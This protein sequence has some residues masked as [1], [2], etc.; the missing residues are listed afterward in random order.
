MDFLQES[1]GLGPLGLVLVF[2]FEEQSNCW[3]R[4]IAAIA[5]ETECVVTDYAVN[6]L[7]KQSL[8]SCRDPH[9]PPLQQTLHKIWTVRAFETL[10][11]LQTDV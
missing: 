11:V 2:K 9:Q 6:N 1:H 4:E 7:S 8:G 5:I 10:V 3:C